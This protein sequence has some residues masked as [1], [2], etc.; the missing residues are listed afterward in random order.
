MNIFLTNHQPKTCARDHCKVHTRKMITEYAQMLCTAHREL[1]GATP[2]F[3]VYKWGYS[4]GKKIIKEA[5]EWRHLP[6]DE[7]EQI[8]GKMVLKSHFYYKTTHRGHPSSHWVR[9]SEAHYLWLYEVFCHL[10]D[11]FH[12]N[13]GFHHKCN[14]LRESLYRPPRNIKKL[15][16]SEPPACM[17]EEFIIKGQIAES[18]QGYLNSKFNDWKTRPK[19][20]DTSY[21]ESTKP[22]WVTQ[23]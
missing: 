12:K 3:L 23:L 9:T 4:K 10:L 14:E 16:W 20:I 2:V 1:D 22:Q 13:R 21:F 8:D 17:P 5:P 15:G 11:K 6:G 18:Y 7:Y 19:P